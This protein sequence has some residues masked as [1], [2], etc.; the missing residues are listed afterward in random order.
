MD[1]ETDQ[2]GLVN[3][4]VDVVSVEKIGD[5]VVETSTVVIERTYDS[6]LLEIEE[7]QKEIYKAN[8]NI[9]YYTKIKVEKE[10]ELLEKQNLIAN[11][12]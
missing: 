12:E 10:Q 6:Y 7:I 8:E 4:S 11:L 2:R 9:A 1:N 3:K 5:N